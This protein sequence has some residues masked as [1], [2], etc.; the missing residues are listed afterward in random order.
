M[1][2]PLLGVAAVPQPD[3]GRWLRDRRDAC[4]AGLVAGGAACRRQRQHLA[5][6]LLRFW[7]ET[8][9]ALLAILEAK[10]AGAQSVN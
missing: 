1:P 3:R 8:G 2:A 9:E 5:G 7:A 4:A 6:A 10:P